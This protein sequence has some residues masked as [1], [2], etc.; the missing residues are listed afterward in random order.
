MKKFAHKAYSTMETSAVLQY[1]DTSEKGLARDIASERLR[2]FGE[3]SLPKDRKKSRLV[4]F[5]RQ[6]HSPL[7]YII[8]VAAVVSIVIG[9]HSDAFFILIVVFI[10]TIVG[11]FQEDKAEQALAALQG[12]MTHQAVVLRGG[13]P[14]EV[15]VKELVV[16][17][18]V[19]VS[20]GDYVAADGRMLY[21]DHV[22]THEAVLTGESE[23]VR[24]KADTLSHVKGI[25]DQFNMFFAGSY[26]AEGDG[27][28]VV[29][30]TGADTELGKIASLVRNQKQASEPLKQEFARLSHVIGGCVLVAIAFFAVIGI[31][32]GQ[33]VQEVFITSTALV[34]SAIP[35]GLLPAVTMVMVFGVRRLAKQRA[36]VRKLSSTETIGAITTICSDKTGTLTEGE[37]RVET[38]LTGS[39]RLTDVHV[40]DH[41]V[42]Q[43]ASIAFDAL[44]SVER[45][46][47][48]GSLVND[49]FVEEEGLLVENDVQKSTTP[50]VRGRSTDKALLLGGMRHGLI[51][52]VFLAD[53]ALVAKIP[54]SSER[55]FASRIYKNLATDDHYV[56][57]VGAPERIFDRSSHVVL[58]DGR[59]VRTDHKDVVA[60]EKQRQTLTDQGLRVLACGW[61]KVDSSALGDVYDRAA[62]EVRAI[63]LLGY[64][65]V[66]DPVRLEAQDALSVA[67][68]AGIRPLIVTGDHAMT[69]RAIIAKLGWNVSA[70]EIC[71]GDVVEK[72]DQEELRSRVQTTSIFARVAP[73][74]KIRIVKALQDNGE[75]VAMVGDGVNDAPALKAA[76][77]GIS[78]GNGTDITKNVA[79]MVLLDSSFATI[80]GAIEQ[81]RAIFE[82]IRRIIIYL[83]SD[84]FSA[85][86]IFFVAM[87]LGFPLPL[88][89]AQILWIN[90]IEDSL[91]NIALTTEKDTKGIMK[92]PP[93]R[94]GEP[95]LSRLHKQF[96]IVIFVIS[97]LA[98]VGVY[99][100]MLQYTDDIALVRTVTFALIAFDSLALT[101]VLRSFRR[102]IFRRDLFH[103]QWI[104]YAVAVSFL[105]LLAGIYVSPLTQFLGT[106]ALSPIHWIVI[107]AVT[108]IEVIVFEF[109]KK[110]IFAY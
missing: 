22:A 29:T 68:E 69:V 83:V 33:T 87:I 31:M 45:V 103:N 39:G 58:D 12:S 66:E 59:I 24:K 70:D 4:L 105:F 50:V 108:V 7:V 89:A 71:T 18:I 94:V 26:I 96:M 67:K 62:M 80:I 46:L 1:L 11:F 48:I 19:R 72:M 102:S 64:I 38:V 36:L 107:V 99:F 28:Y 14:Y 15:D 6:F 90:L 41:I 79:D 49:A 98:A 10:N 5:L 86:F 40:G 44:N 85:L 8:L 101:Y 42:P 78:M 56:F 23:S 106:V 25:G 34:V 3:N 63:H 13:K 97:G 53:H 110:R 57:V 81:G 95:I 16:G 51:P 74:H 2:V 82:N 52:D 21:G 100:W 20:A 43:R 75:I 65:G 76:H 61:R 77:V 104:N 93:R 30:E 84:N 91:P 17:D 73:V 55:K 60:L 47:L 27:A 32:R 37:M 54:F 35:E 109:A 88:L 92:I 9:H